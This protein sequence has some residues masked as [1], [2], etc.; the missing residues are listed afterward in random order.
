M[1]HVGSNCHVFKKISNNK[2]LADPNGKKE[3]KFLK[4]I[5]KSISYEVY[6]IA[7]LAM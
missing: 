4:H 6:S 3:N 1:E 7:T 2:D 5:L